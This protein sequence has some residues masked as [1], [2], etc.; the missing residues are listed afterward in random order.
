M[1]CESFLDNN[2]IYLAFFLTLAVKYRYL[3]KQDIVKLIKRKLR[4]KAG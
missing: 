1:L 4:F 2:Y 3:D